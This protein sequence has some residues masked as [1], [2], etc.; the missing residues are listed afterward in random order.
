MNQTNK[1][2][3]TRSPFPNPF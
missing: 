3:T 2:V 1:T